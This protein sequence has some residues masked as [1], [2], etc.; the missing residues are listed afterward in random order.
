MEEK[1]HACLNCNQVMTRQNPKPPEQRPY[2]K[3]QCGYREYVMPTISQRERDEVAEAGHTPIPWAVYPNPM[4]SDGVFVGTA[5]HTIEQIRRLD[6]IE[7]KERPIKMIFWCQV[8]PADGELIVRAVNAHDDML[9][10]LSQIIAESAHDIAPSLGA[11]EVAR[12]AI[13]KATGA[14]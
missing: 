14:A 8:S 2:W 6:Y 3:C 9:A 13:A 1:P 4:R 5:E 12:A 11:L 10:A 7:E